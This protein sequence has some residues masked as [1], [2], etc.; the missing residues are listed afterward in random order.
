MTI[1]YDRSGKHTKW[2]VLV[3]LADKPKLTQVP[4]SPETQQPNN[5]DA[6]EAPPPGLYKQPL[7]FHFTHLFLFL[8]FYH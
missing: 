1:E 8:R 4:A 6:D 7:C 2:G 3:N 5:K